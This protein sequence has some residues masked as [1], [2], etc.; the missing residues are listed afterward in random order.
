LK[1]LVLGLVAAVALALSIAACSGTP[2]SSPTSPSVAVGAAL[3]AVETASLKVTSPALIDP[4]D[5]RTIDT[6]RP[7]F[8][9][10]NAAGTYENIGLAYQ[11]EVTEQTGEVIYSR[12]VGESQDFSTNTMDFDLAENKAYS[13]R[14]R[15]VLSTG[16][17][18]WS[19]YADFRTPKPVVVVPTPVPGPDVANAY[20]T[21]DP[22]PGQRLPRPNHLG[23]L[24]AL[25]AA[26]PSLLRESCQD[27]GGNWRFM[28]KAVD[29]LRILDMR[30]GYNCKRGNCNDI[31][32][33][34]VSYHWGP[35]QDE[36]STQVYCTDIISGH[37]G[38]A[39]SL[40]W[41]DVTTI[42]FESGTVCKVTARRPGR[43]VYPLPPS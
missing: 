33:D 28:D 36:G 4:T 35:G 30:Y 38:P 34:V 42:T 8:V 24:L 31:S 39:P 22:P 19:G 3:A 17:G 6:R 12:V 43:T 25:S 14:V 15:A 16:Q 41:N 1:Q 26:D 11:I 2:R 40:F 7:T 29:T 10:A 21:P 37:C 13:W 20:R 32:H 9:W 27:G 18:P 23:V 5:G